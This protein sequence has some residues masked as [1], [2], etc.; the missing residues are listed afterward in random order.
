VL[1]PA[2]DTQRTAGYRLAP[3]RLLAVTHESAS[4][5]GAF[6]HTVTAVASSEP[7]F[8]TVTRTGTL[9]PALA[10]PGFGIEAERWRA[11]EHGA[12]RNP[13]RQLEPVGTTE[14]TA[15]GATGRTAAGRKRRAR[16]GQGA[17]RGRDPGRARGEHAAGQRAVPAVESVIGA[18]VMV[19]LPG[20]EP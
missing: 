13:L 17:G 8:V 1:A 12:G 2:P 19:Q 15:D 3:I 7:V 6:T 10:T 14:R 5:L 18:V 4:R 11:V 9:R 16:A 20:W